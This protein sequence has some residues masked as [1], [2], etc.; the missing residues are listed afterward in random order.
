[1]C[2]HVCMFFLFQLC[3]ISATDEKHCSL[4][5]KN[6]VNRRYLLSFVNSAALLDST[7]MPVYE[8][9]TLAPKIYLFTLALVHPPGVLNCELSHR[10]H[11]DFSH[12]LIQTFMQF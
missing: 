11:P 7:F 3:N 12:Y 2:V 1:M 4:S 5:M 8:K 10:L 6:K 9:D